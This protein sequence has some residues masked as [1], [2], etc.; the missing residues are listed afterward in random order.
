MTVKLD[1]DLAAEQ[2]LARLRAERGE[3]PLIPMPGQSDELAVR[4]NV[5]LVRRVVEEAFAVLARA[6]DEATS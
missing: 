1:V 4:R 3:W 6:D 5:R 2:V